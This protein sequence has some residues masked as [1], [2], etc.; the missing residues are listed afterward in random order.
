MHSNFYG[1]MIF[2]KCSQ[3]AELS[4]KNARRVGTRVTR[5]RS[6]GCQRSID[7]LQ[8]GATKTQVEFHCSSQ[9]DSPPWNANGPAPKGKNEPKK[10]P[11]REG[12]HFFAPPATLRF[13]ERQEHMRLAKRVSGSL[14]LFSRA[15]M[16]TG[17]NAKIEMLLGHRGF[18]RAGNIV[19]QF[20]AKR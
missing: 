18:I 15:P 3:C 2:S 16:L 4:L 19:I 14:M 6:L 13:F 7:N 20:R 11:N 5:A 17:R 1:I 9:T 10:R 12:L 8:A